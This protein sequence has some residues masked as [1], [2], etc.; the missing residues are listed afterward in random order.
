[1]IRWRA[2]DKSRPSAARHAPAMGSR[3]RAIDIGAARA[4]EVLARLPAEARTARLTSGLGQAEV[5]SALG[6][7]VA[8]YS[9]IE[10]GMS[11]ELSI[12]TAVRLF[13][14]LGLDLSIRAYPAGDPIRD[15]AQAS[16]LERLHLHCHRSIVWRTEVPFPISGDLRAWDATAVCSAVR[17][18][19]EAETRIRDVQALD[20]RLA[21]KERDGAMDRVILLVLDTRNNRAALRSHGSQLLLRFPVPGQ[22]ALELLGVGADP[23]GNALILL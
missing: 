21:L 10:R 12:A 22:R 23:G 17:A 16:L 13:A 4:R 5:A 7:S 14:L 20:R 6:I 18:G 9:R 19:V 11:P 8:Q 1:M 2:P 15:V 3:E